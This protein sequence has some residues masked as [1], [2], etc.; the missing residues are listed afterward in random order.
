MVGS[1]YLQEGYDCLF[2]TFCPVS[3][4]QNAVSYRHNTQ[5]QISEH[6]GT[7]KRNHMYFF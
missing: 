3:S 7:H 6:R 2:E 4:H 5:Y 1:D